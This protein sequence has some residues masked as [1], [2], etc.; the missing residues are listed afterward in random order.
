MKKILTSF[1]A[2]S[3]AVFVSTVAQ[4]RDQIRVVGSSTVYPFATVI[5]LCLNL[6]PLYFKG[7]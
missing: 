3:A 2:I 4:A 5:F 1:V 7:I 6:K